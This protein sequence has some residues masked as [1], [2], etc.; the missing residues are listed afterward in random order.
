MQ[1][2]RTG[3]LG[4]Q[5]GFDGGLNIG[6]FYTD[7]N[8]S[9]ANAAANWTYANKNIG[10]STEYSICTKNVLKIIIKTRA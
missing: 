6:A 4:L 5:I 8:I 7:T 1:V 9:T 2:I 3:N 10:D